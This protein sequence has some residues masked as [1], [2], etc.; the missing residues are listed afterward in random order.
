MILGAGLLQL[1]AIRIAKKLGVFPIVA[2]INPKAIGFEEDSIEKL[3][4]STTDTRMILNAAREH[5]IDGIITVASDVPVPTV[6]YVC[7]QLG[8]RG[9][10]T[11]TAKRATNKADM[12]ICLSESNVPMPQ[13]SVATT[14][15]ELCEAAKVFDYKVV[16]KASDNSGNRGISMVENPKNLTAL[17]RAFDY[18]KEN[19]KDNRILIEE[20]M[21]GPEFSVEGISIDGKFN[22]IQ[23]TD[24]I[25]NGAPYFVEMGHT[26]PSEQPAEVVAS[27]ID[28]A[29]KAVKAVGIENGPSHTEIKLT[30][31][32]PKIVELG[33]RL[34]GGCITS[35]LVPLSTGVDMIEACIKIAL[36]EKPDIEPKYSAGAAIRF[37]NSHS[38]VFT[39]VSGVD[40]ALKSEGVTEVNFFKPVGSTIPDLKTGLDRIG[41]VIAYGETRSQAI[42]NCERAISQIHI[43]IS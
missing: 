36:G 29:R 38:G 32:G 25:T 16:I 6:A 33:A 11:L 15:T 43:N 22:A 26:Q 1:P 2:D 34:G 30:S 40:K 18:A 19:S 14:F 3:I 13:F 28:V 5:H 39:A 35:H 37:F 23:V 31:D 10:S 24:K 42:E 17:K 27:I 20:Y 41:Y 9:V 12:R 21:N 8:L 4:I 7:E